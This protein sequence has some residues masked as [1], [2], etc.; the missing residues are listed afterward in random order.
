VPTPLD[1]ALL[2]VRQAILDEHRLVRAVASGRRSGQSARWLRAEV[3]PVA[4]KAGD[5]LQITTFDARQAFTAN[6]T[7]A[8][9]DEPVAAL[10]AEPFASWHVELV[11]ETLQVQVTRRGAAI[12]SSSREERARPESFRHD[13]VKP[14]LVDVDAPYLRMLG[15]TTEAGQ[16][17]TSRRDKFHQVEEFVRVLDP[18]VREATTDGRLPTDRAIRIVDLGC[19]NAYLTFAAFQH[20][21]VTL[22][23]DVTMVG[24]DQKLQAREHNAS[25]AAEL[26]WD[27]RMHFFAGDIATASV[28]QPP[29][30][31][32]ALHACD[33]ATDDALARAVGWRA[34]VVLAAPCCHHDLQRQIKAGKAVPDPYGVVMRHGILRERFVDVLTDALRAALLRQFGYRTDVIEFVDTAHTPRNVLLR[35]VRTGGRAD[36]STVAEYQALVAQWNVRPR[37]AELLEG[38][39]GNPA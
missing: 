13:R 24:V 39:P 17:R 5:R 9:A 37:L 12:V 16:V 26:G 11:D 29:D 6:H 4:L 8:E 7:W 25:V 18:V 32:M 38:V 34:A 3:R 36:A 15:V 35:A 10:V 21:S 20:L 22:G 1:A 14:R 19:G 30:V 2:R 33:T 23:L 28:A 31:V 27:E